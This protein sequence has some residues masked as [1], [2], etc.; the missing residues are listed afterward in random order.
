MARSLAES[1]GKGLIGASKLSLKELHALIEHLN[2]L[3]VQMKAKEGIVDDDPDITD[4]LGT[5]HVQTRAWYN[6]GHSS[7]TESA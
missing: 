6:P 7:V 3:Y 4:I 5:P 1:V 2:L